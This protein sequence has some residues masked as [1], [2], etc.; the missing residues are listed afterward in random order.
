MTDQEQRELLERFRSWLYKTAYEMIGQRNRDLAEDLAQEGW[1][2]IWEASKKETEN[3]ADIDAWLRTVARFRMRKEIRYLL[4]EK[5]DVR[6]TQYAEPSDNIW[7]AL[8]ADLGYVELAYHRGQILKAINELPPQQRKYIMLRYWGGY[9]KPE[10]T[11]YFG[12]IPNSTG[13]AARK[14]LR[15]KLKHLASV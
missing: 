11:A 8:Q 4:A 12:Y 15:K 5:R 2:A 7:S 1:I 9:T 13:Q 10:L 14:N 6:R 3:I